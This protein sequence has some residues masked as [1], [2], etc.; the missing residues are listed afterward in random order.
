[1]IRTLI[2]VFAIGLIVSASCFG[3]AASMGHYGF[4]G[5]RDWNFDSDKDGLSAG[6]RATREITWE[7]SDHLTLNFGGTVHYTQ[8]PTPKVT[9]TGPQGAV[10][11][12]RL[13]GGTISLESHR[14]SSHGIVVDV[15]APAVTRFE[16]NGSG[17]LTIDG[18]AQDTLDVEIN[19]S[20]DVTAKGAARLVDID[21]HGSG[22]ADVSK[23]V[24]DETR[25]NLMG[26]GDVT[27]APLKSAIVNINGSGD[28]TV[29]SNPPHKETSI[30]GSG[31][32]DF[33]PA[34]VEEETADK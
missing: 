8:G 32:I 23:I 5:D 12:V 13:E 2:F 33:D 22:D 3:V 34:F 20:G 31:D 17:E 16:L 28:V 9:V 18:Y 11:K 27:I 4:K 14:L 6:P 7:G 21:V 19:G 15:V 24:G 25:A 29:R 26:S 30:H 10:E 1:M